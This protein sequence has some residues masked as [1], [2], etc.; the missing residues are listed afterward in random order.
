MVQ[1]I[2]DL[3]PQSRALQ[4]R[5][6][7]LIELDTAGREPVQ[8]RPVCNIVVD[9]L[10]ERVGLLKHH[11]DAAAQL[12]GV[13]APLVN[14]LAIES[15]RAG[16]ARAKRNNTSKAESTTTGGPSGGILWR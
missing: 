2:L 13:D 7:E 5:A 8:A 3:V 16:D 1:P 15:N 12:H 6:H 4:A 14:V 9:R 11:A 10:R